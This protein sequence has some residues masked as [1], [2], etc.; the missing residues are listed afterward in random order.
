[1]ECNVTIKVPPLYV[2]VLESQ[3]STCFVPQITLELDDFLIGQKEESSFFTFNVHGVRDGGALRQRGTLEKK[4][5]MVF[6][7][8]KCRRAITS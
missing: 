2:W 4:I 7:E 5:S 8:R 3:P 1:M 6:L